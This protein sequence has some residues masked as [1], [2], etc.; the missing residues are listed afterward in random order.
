MPQ[1]GSF[2][3][4]VI[5]L[6][7][8]VIVVVNLPNKL[9][10]DFSVTDKTKIIVCN[11]EDEK[12]GFLVDEVND[13]MFIEDRYVSVSKNAN[14]LVKSTISLNEGKR[15]ILELKLEKLVD[16]EEIKNIDKE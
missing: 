11:I 12:V 6:R 14:S 16:L 7:G 9:S 8:S 15:V 10:F 1:S 2:I 5:N 13:I 3:E 4:G